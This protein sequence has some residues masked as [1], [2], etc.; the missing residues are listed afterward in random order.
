MAHRAAANSSTRGRGAAAI[1]AVALAFAPEASLAAPQSVQEIAN[2][3]GTDRQQIL[4]TG[5]KAE[6]ALMVY[7]TGTQIQPLIDRFE[8]KYPYIHVQMPRAD[9]GDVARQV[10]E[11]YHAGL[12]QVDVFELS[13]YGLLPLRDQDIL[14]PFT[15]PEGADFAPTAFEAGHHWVS[16]RESYIGIGYS[17]KKIAPADA[18]KTYQ[19]MLDPKWKGRMSLSAVFATSANWV[20]A[21]V[22]S[23]GADY[24]RKLGEQDIRV[25]QLTGRAIANLMISGEESI[26]PTTYNS[27]VE[28]SNA[29]GAS[30]AWVAPGPVPVTDTSVALASK[31]PHP[32]A[33]MLFVDFLMSKEGQAL[34]LKIGYSPARTG[35]TDPNLP[36]IRKLYLTNRPNYLQE[37]E[38][39]VALTRQA[40][41][42]GK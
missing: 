29:E 17:T 1:V 32:H 18:P 39:W 23:E 40:F 34:Y 10:Y 24:V 5:A 9:S 36:P 6:G 16:V 14:L 7:A 31:S 41:L 3:T 20:G 13:S 8:Q 33:A 19:D 35:M 28:A 37:Y 12:F 11:E 27:H 2:Y 22:L 25:H 30:L 38:Q 15:S 42:Q 26:S 4:E 21:M